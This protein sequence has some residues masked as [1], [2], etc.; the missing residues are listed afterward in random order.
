MI[1]LVNYYL[2]HKDSPEKF[3]RSYKFLDDKVKDDNSNSNIS[4]KCHHTF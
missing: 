3:K 4:V 1:I 2:Q